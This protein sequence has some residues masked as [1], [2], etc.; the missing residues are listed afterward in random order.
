M[1]KTF[2]TAQEWKEKGNVEFIKGNWTDALNYYTNALE[3]AEEEK[4]VYYKN[5]AAAYLKLHDYD[6]VIE[7]C[8]NA[9]KIS[10]NDPK[11]LFRRCQALE[12]LERFEEAYQD[13]KNVILFDPDN[14]NIQSIIAHCEENLIIHIKVSQ[15]MDLIFNM[16]ADKMKRKTA[17]RDL[18]MLAQKRIGAEEIFNQE[19][20]IKIIQLVKDE[21]EEDIIWN[22]IIIVGQLCKENINRTKSIIEIIH[23]SWFLEMMNS[24]IF[25]RVKA[26]SFGLQTILNTY[27]GMG[28]D[29]YSKPN[30]ALCET[31]KNEINAI[32]LCLLNSIT[33]KTITGMSR[34]EII[35]LITNN[36]CH[37]ALNWA[38]QFI[39][40][41]GVQN[42]LEVAG[43]IKE[44]K[45]KSSM[46]VTSSTRSIIISCL[47]QAYINDNCDTAKEKFNNSL[48]EFIT[49]KLQSSDIELKINVVVAITTLLLCPLNVGLAI[50]AK[51]EILDTI[52]V[53]AAGNLMK[54]KVV[55]DYMAAAVTKKKISPIVNQANNILRKLY[56]SKCDSIRIRALV[57]WCKFSTFEDTKMVII[58]FVNGTATK[59][60]ETCKRLLIGPKNENDMRKWGAQ[61]LS[62]LSFDAEVKEK[63]TYDQQAMESIMKLA[64]TSEQSVL[65]N[66]VVILMNL[67]NICIKDEIIPEMIDF[68]KFAN[69]YASVHSKFDGIDFVK[70]RIN[71]LADGG[72][73]NVLIR[74]ADTE[75]DNIKEL[76]VRIFL[77]LFNHGE[78]IH[79]IIAQGGARILL[80]LALNGTTKG[81]KMASR[82]LVKLVITRFPLI[83]V[84]FPIFDLEKIL[85]FIP[86]FMNLL[87]SESSV[88]E[89]YETLEALAIIV[90]MDR[91]AQRYMLEKGEFRKIIPYI[92]SG[93]YLLRRASLK[94]IKWFI[95]ETEVVQY[96]EQ[97][98]NRIKQLVKLV[99]DNDKDTCKLAALNFAPLV[100][101][102]R[103]VYEKFFNLDNWLNFLLFLLQ[104]GEDMLLFCGLEIIK[105][106]ML[107]SKSFTERF[108]KMDIMKLIISLS[109]NNFIHIDIRRHA[110]F[111]V[112]ITQNCEYETQS[113]EAF[114]DFDIVRTDMLIFQRYKKQ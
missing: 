34:D 110:H 74:L 11:A 99:E 43:E 24:T 69:R 105:S 114:D 95:L 87:N 62:Y 42:L 58:P 29:R 49:D 39:D 66:V 18:L 7:D 108:V 89:T 36:I 15:L 68:E 19:G 9:L 3:T 60:V 25:Q 101:N 102:S 84:F 31:H 22:A 5:R 82:I 92:Y 94:V 100:L 33:S 40:L 73:T 112:M 76:C 13:A 63:L 77:A 4:A 64:M 17:M 109:N 51:E 54:Q 91:C 50:A 59:L 1:A 88:S 47:T 53:M 14:K 56:H 57:T 35:M 55:C 27:S 26:A 30:K 2:V 90:G 70:K 45:H 104:S 52:F 28:N 71:I 113:L 44:S 75:N 46:N 98:D 83:I 48:N 20:V 8:N 111:I 85:E 72:I 79:I 106:K 32:L 10:S 107:S 96:F 21:K 41:R 80:P 37:D 65:Y 81:K 103:L 78:I 38:E 16:K 93:Q 6:N 61:G 97:N 67:C 12:A 23:L 86:P